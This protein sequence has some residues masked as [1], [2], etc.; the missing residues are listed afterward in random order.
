MP[1]R[2]IFT[3]KLGYCLLYLDFLLSNEGK[4]CPYHIYLKLAAT[5]TFT[6]NNFKIQTIVPFCILFVVFILFD[7]T[8]SNR[9]LVLLQLQSL[10]L[11]TDLNHP[12]GRVVSASDSGAKQP[13]DR[14]PPLGPTSWYMRGSVA[15][16][17]GLVA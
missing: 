7:V 14:S 5:S 8:K 15:E 4:K 13:Q 2:S 17:L 12:G 3:F 11:S 16:T 1:R 6:S 9:S 10:I